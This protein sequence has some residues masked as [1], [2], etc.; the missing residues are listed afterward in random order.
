M[1]Y[2]EHRYYG[3]S[4]PT[5]DTSSKNL[6]YLTVQQ[7]LADLAHFIVDI[8]AN[9]SSL[10]KSGVIV[11]G[12]SYSATIATWMRQKYPHLVSGAWASS[13]PLHAKVDFY[14]YNELMTESI[15]LAGGDKCLRRFENAFK[16]L[17]GL[18]TASTSS[19]G[20]LAKITKNFNLCEPLESCRDLP[21]FFYEMSDTVTGLVQGHRYDNI[22]QACEFITQEKFADD[23]EAFG[24]WIV[25]KKKVKCIDMNYA[26]LVDKFTNVSWDSEANGQLR[27]WIYQT[28]DMFGWFQSGTSLKQAF[29][30]RHPQLSYF[31]I[32]CED[33]YGQW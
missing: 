32:M 3:K 33:F 10:E 9:N 24:A 7:A 12:A 27:Q 23:V 25:Q 22:Q 16:Q 26:K 13:A 19:S 15:R 17:E 5:S 20:A 6:K 4:R 31:L 2:T 29:G 28:C 8:K 11:V 18:L 14:E 21:H 30:S 1:Y